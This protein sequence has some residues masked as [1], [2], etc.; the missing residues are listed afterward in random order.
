MTI[1]FENVKQKTTNSSSEYS[2]AQSIDGWHMDDS[3][4]YHHYVLVHLGNGEYR[5]YK[6][7]IRV[8]WFKRYD[9]PLTF[10]EVQQEYKNLVMRNQ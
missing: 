5:G 4:K 8:S 6:D 2:G 1:L 9:K 3:S 10:K 7:G